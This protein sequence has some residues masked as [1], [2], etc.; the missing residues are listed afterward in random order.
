MP[1]VIIW[2]WYL[3]PKILILFYNGLRNLQNFAKSVYISLQFWNFLIF[4]RLK[5][6]IA[7]MF[8][9]VPNTLRKSNW[10][11]GTIQFALKRPNDRFTTCT[12]FIN[13][14]LPR[15]FMTTNN[16]HIWFQTTLYDPE[17]YPLIYFKTF[18]HRAPKPPK[19]LTKRGY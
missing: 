8:S 18:R 15:T 16:D 13:S 9:M 1:N 14:I 4:F 17:M 19:F 3:S 12:D 2:P 11:G 7:K 5:I 10:V 6:K